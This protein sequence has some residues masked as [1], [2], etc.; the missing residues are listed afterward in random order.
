M[1][2]KGKTME[3][4]RSLLDD[5]KQRNGM[6]S[7]QALATALEVRR[8]RIYDYYRGIRKPDNY[9]CNRIAILLQRPLNEII[10]VVELDAEKDEK[11]R[12][13]WQDYYKSIGGMAASVM[14][15]VSLVVTLEV[16]S[17]SEA[18]ANQGVTKADLTEYKLCDV[19]MQWGF[20][21]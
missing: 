18:H 21:R 1:E 2:R 10:S 15:S 14:L 19:W 16:T 3:T 4:I 12:Q 13:V 9:M 11:R 17:P 7:D 8:Q 5:V 20:S 6:D